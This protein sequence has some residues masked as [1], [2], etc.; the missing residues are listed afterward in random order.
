MGWQLFL[1]FWCFVSHLLILVVGLLDSHRKRYLAAVCSATGIAMFVGSSTGL[2][3]GMY[4]RR[5]PGFGGG[6]AAL[7]SFVRG[8][9]SGFSFAPPWANI[10]VNTRVWGLSNR[11][12]GRISLFLSYHRIPN[13][14]QN[15][16]SQLR[17]Y[18]DIKVPPNTGGVRRT[19]S[20]QSA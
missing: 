9:G 4:G 1:S 14:H 8:L 12:K 19:C 5:G 3:R 13:P 17:G 7:R 18:D 15:D 6:E 2:R 10:K 11:P 20:R 16:S